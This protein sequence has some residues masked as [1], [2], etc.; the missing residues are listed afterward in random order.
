M[1]Q[2]TY[3]LLSR[4]CDLAVWPPNLILNK[5]CMFEPLIVSNKSY[6]TRSQFSR[7]HSCFNNTM[8]VACPGFIGSH[9]PVVNN[10][11]SKSSVITD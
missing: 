3:T 1:S 9:F 4:S 7:K 10:M 5:L 6:R 11:R 2:N 8:T